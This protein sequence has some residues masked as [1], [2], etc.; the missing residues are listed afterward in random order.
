VVTDAEGKV[1]AEA[2]KGQKLQIRTQ[3]QEIQSTVDQ[4]RKL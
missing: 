2:S 3:S 1:V 4:V